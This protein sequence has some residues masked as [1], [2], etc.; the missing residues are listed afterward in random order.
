LEARHSFSEESIATT[1]L[2]GHALILSSPNAGINRTSIATDIDT[3]T[4]KLQEAEVM[5]QIFYKYKWILIFIAAF[6]V[7]GRAE[8]INLQSWDRVINRPQRF[9]VLPQFSNEAVLDRE[10]QLVWE[11]QPVSEPPFSST[12]NWSDA[13][14]VCYSKHVGGRYGW[15]LP[16]LEELA[17]LM[18]PETPIAEP[19]LPSGHPFSNVQGHFYWSATTKTDAPNE[20]MGVHFALRAIVSLDKTMGTSGNAEV[21]CVRGG[22]GYDGGH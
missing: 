14:F 5:R 20:A 12:R 9:Q 10:T 7:I 17:S 15:R 18:D 11:Q 3:M 19:A 13:V 4:I 16:T 22:H 8:A 6:L 21:W 2:T 1:T